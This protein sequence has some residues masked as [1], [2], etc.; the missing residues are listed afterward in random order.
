MYLLERSGLDLSAVERNTEVCD[1]RAED[2]ATVRDA[3]AA[4]D[5]AYVAHA[6]PYMQRFFQILMDRYG[7]VGPDTAGEGGYCPQ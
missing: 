3:I 7:N 1:V 5:T 4:G 2:I 6:A